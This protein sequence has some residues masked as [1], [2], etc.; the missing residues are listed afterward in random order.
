MDLKKILIYALIFGLG[1]AVGKVLKINITTR[2]GC[3]IAR[4]KLEELKR[5]KTSESSETYL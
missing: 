1:F 4:Q 3:P 2:G 5:L